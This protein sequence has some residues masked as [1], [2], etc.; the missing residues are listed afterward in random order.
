ML[1]SALALVA[2]LGAVAQA[3]AD[4]PEKQ[5]YV[6][7]QMSLAPPSPQMLGG[8]LPGQMTPYFYSTIPRCPDGMILVVMPLSY[9]LKC[10]VPATLVDP[11]QK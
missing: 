5:P 7:G 3:A 11:V 10:A 9:R 2:V 6:P 4:T 8:S 1:R